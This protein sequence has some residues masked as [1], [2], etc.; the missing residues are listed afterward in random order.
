MSLFN[1]EMPSVTLDDVIQWFT[2]NPKEP[3]LFNSALFLGMFIVFYFIYIGLRKTFHARLLYVVVFS[4]FFYYKSSGLYLFILIGSSLMDYTFANT[5][6]HSTNEAKKRFLLTLSVVLNLGLL[7]YF[8]YTNFF[9]DGFNFFADTKFHLDDLILPV[10]ISFYTF[11][12]ISYIIEIYR[13]EIEPTKSFLDYLF[14][15]SFF[16]Q[17]VAGPIVRAKDFIPQIYSNLLVT[18]DQVNEGMLLIIGGVL[19]KAVISDYISINFVDRVF[20]APNSYTAFENLMASYGYAIQ[21]YCDFSGYSD[22]AIG[23]ALLL[24]YRLPMNFNV[25]YQSTSI[26]EF[27]RRWHISLSTWLKDFLYIS[28]GGNRKGTFGGYF[29][30][31]LFFVGIIGWGIYSYNASIYPLI[32]GILSFVVFLLT[33]ALSKTKQKSLFTN[34]NLLT[35][36]LLGG[37]W[38]GASLRFIVW[39]ALHGIALAVH[40]LV[41]ELFPRKK[42][43]PASFIWRVISIILTFHF[44]A[45]CWIFFRANSFETALNII[46]NIADLQFDWEAWQT[47]IMGYKNVFLLIAIGFVWHFIPKRWMAIP[48]Q[49]FN[50]A[51][52]FVKSVILGF[53]FWVVY[54]TATAG[55]QPFI[56]FQF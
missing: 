45:F 20:D 3:L 43:K 29:F 12:S 42:D 49:W 28:V 10:G 41:M 5:I 31:G 52:I 44:V 8:K 55:P 7:G 50:V 25:P 27:W 19:K 23:I 2:F 22:M 40:K 51:P 34:F 15:I 53:V 26:T 1:I 48:Q 24:G 36:M 13:K 17:L 9:L 33:I 47:I 54:A 46:Y 16:P 32:I 21:I 38:H 14:F 6:H 11:Q 4:L 18:R 56:Y 35:T 37:L 30:P 39:G